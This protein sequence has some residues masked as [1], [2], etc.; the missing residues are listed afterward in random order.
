MLLK[1]LTLRNY[2]KY[3]DAYVEFPDG[4]IG[5]IG[6]NGVGKTTLIEAI[7]WVLF[8][9]HA[10]RTTKE[11]IKRDGASPH[12]PCSVAL[13]F[14]L[15]GDGY[16]V[17]REMVGKNLMPKASLM[18]N[19]K[20]IT[21][22]ADETT[23]VIT[24]K[25]GMDYLSFF[26]SVFARQKELNALSIMKAAERKKLVLRMLGIERIE[27]SIQTIREDKRDN[28]KRVEGIKA[29][30]VDKEGRKKIDMLSS[31]QEELER[32][33]EGLLP[34]IKEIEAATSIKE[35][36]VED[37]KEELEIGTRNYENYVALSGKLS[38]RRSDLENVGKRKEEK[39][40]ELADLL[41]KKERLEEIAD[42]ETRYFQFRERKEQLDALRENYQRKL[43][44]VKREK[45]TALELQ[46]REGK[47][48][49]L[50]EQRVELED[51]EEQVNA[52]KREIEAVQKQKERIHASLGAFKSQ[53]VQTKKEIEERTRKKK[54]IEELGSEGE[55]PL[56]ERKLGSHYEWLL[57]KLHE[58]LQTK[59][60]DLL[61]VFT[62]YKQKKEERASRERAEELLIQKDKEL[63]KRVIEK[64]AVDTRIAHEE[65]ELE[66][67]KT[68]LGLI[69][70]DLT[71]IRDVEFDANAY[72]NVI[73]TLN[74]LE[75]VYREILGLRAEIGRIGDVKSNVRKLRDLKRTTSEAI[76]VLQ[77]QIEELAFD[78]REYEAKK[79]KY[80]L[81][82]EEF[83]ESR[84]K[85]L[86]KRNEFENVCRERER[87]MEDIAELKRLLEEKEKEE[88]E[89]LY[90]SML[91]K[92]MN[93]F[94]VYMVGRIRPMLS[95]YASEMLRR[96][97]DG[98]YSAM[99]LDEN[100]DVF[101]YDEG[102]PYELNRFSGGEEDLANLC[103]RL[104][105]SAVV[106][107]RSAIQTNFIILDE[108]FGSQDAF[109]KR[110]IILALNALSKK[111][112]QIFLITHIEDVRDYMEYVLRVTEDE[113]GVSWVRME[114]G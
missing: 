106:T 108:I 94:K 25:I 3:K 61:T 10:A 114:T 26:T 81:K 99:E 12:E 71:P 28:E 84:L 79:A 21:N 34:I 78:K 111:F 85:L 49:D 54:R 56:C 66:R 40:K 5:I 16:S 6:L 63:D 20:L 35:K 41:V 90:L 42:K 98:K 18:I 44:L 92:L 100:Y 4:V 51:V 7:G 72:K 60:K 47:I 70:A 11:L 24:E 77:R 93:D 55:C 8:G 96:L 43:E 95:D 59:K 22:N 31:K 89:I 80:D 29:A 1:T 19:G 113:A 36:E 37:A 64:R 32:T 102:T 50:K 62:E 65:R 86:A 38:E 2:R 74:N 76:S 17:V 67:W 23:E 105:I 33:Q 101:I 52:V 58:E 109:R 112:R 82:K 107:E 45:K 9:H 104:A 48:S 57:T 73:S 103:L 88:T 69:K 91:E 97:T 39:E 68:E 30:T 87:V 14:E 15:E 75:V 46:K 13:E 27:K 83:A 110:N 53:V